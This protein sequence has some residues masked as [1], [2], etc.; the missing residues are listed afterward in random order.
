MIVLPY[1]ILPEKRAIRVQHFY[2]EDSWWKRGMNRCEL[3]VQ[4]IEN[5]LRMAS[6]LQRLYRRHNRW[7]SYV[8]FRLN[9]KVFNAAACA[10]RIT[11]VADPTFERILM[12]CPE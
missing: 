4:K 10:L 7:H 2:L 5:V 9:E 1:A 3:D 12:A 8:E 6:G 11:Y